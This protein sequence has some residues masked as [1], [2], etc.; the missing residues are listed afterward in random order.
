MNGEGSA[1]G[2]HHE[3]RHLGRMPEGDLIRF[4]NDFLEKYFKFQ[5]LTKL[6]CRN[7]GYHLRIMPDGS[8]SGSLDEN[9]PHVILRRWA[10]ET[11]VVVVKS[12][13]TER[14]LAMNDEGC[15]YGSEALNDD[16]FFVESLEDNKYNT[17][18][19]KKHNWYV[20]LKKNGEPK[21]G[22]EAK[23]S[24]NAVFFVPRP[25]ETSAAAFEEA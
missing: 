18:Q 4:S 20:G 7:G 2:S 15:L 23:L 12:E 6:Y 8:I 14:F 24:Q 10:K 3:S 17:Y 21:S 5:P 16:C 9:D 25:A 19:S 22:R 13:H 1:F 11:S